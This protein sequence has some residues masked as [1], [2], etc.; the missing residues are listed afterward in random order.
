R[1]EPDCLV[2]VGY[3]AVEVAL[4]IVRVASSVIGVRVARIEL[5]RLVVVCDG[6]V[7][8]EQL[9]EVNL[10]PAVVGSGKPR[11]DLY[12]RGEVS[13]GT[14][15]VACD[16]VDVAAVVVGDGCARIAADEFA[17]R[18][19]CKIVVLSLAAVFACAALGAGRC[20]P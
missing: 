11:L 9:D 3:R 7:E 5:D 10:T 18:T 2:V 14:L 20:R 1:V 12:G 6:A 15:V 13:D 19:D 16:E 17:T 4:V 8:I